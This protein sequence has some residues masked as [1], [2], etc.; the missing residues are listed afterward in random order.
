MAILCRTSRLLVVVIFFTLLASGVL[1]NGQALALP[2][3]GRSIPI[4][5]KVVLIGFSEKQIDIAHL[6]WSG[7]GKNLPESIANFDFD[8][9]NDTGVVFRPKYSFS[10]ASSDF[11]D[12]LVTYLRSIEKKGHGKNP[13]F[14]QWQ[15]D[16]KNKDYSVFEP[17]SVNYVV[18]DA[19]SV[20]DWLWNHGQ[21]LG[22]YPENA[23][24]I[25]VAYLPELPSVSWPDVRTFKNSNG[26]TLPKSTPHYYGIAHTD[27][28]LGYKS[29]YRDFMNAW[30]GHHRMWFVDLSAGPVF[31]SEWEDI[32]LQVAVGDN[33]IDLSS[34]FS[35]NWLT[36]YVADYVWQATVNFVV[37]NF[38][39]YPIY[40]PNYQ[41][42]VFILDDRS[43]AEK[44]EVPIQNTLN[45]DMV[46]AAIQDLVPYSKVSV[47]VSFVDVTQQLHDL[48]KSNYEYTDSWIYG[49]V[50]GEPQRYGIVNVKPIY[51]YM[52][53]NL[54]TFEP[55]PNKT[56]DKITIPV[57]AF[58]FTGETYF[59]YPYK[60]YIGKTD[61]ETGALLGIALKEGVFISYNQWEFTRGDQIDPSQPG[62]GEG[63]TQT[64][65]HEVGHEFGLMHPHQ[66]GDIGDFVFSAMGYFT[67]DYTFGQ[68]D[69]DAI[70]RAHVD[71]IYMETE[72]LLNQASTNPSAAQL[73][74]QAENKLSEADSAYNSMK[75][76]DA[77]QPVLAA[78]QL[79][80]Q[81]AQIQYTQQ[82]EAVTQTGTTASLIATEEPVVILAIGAVIGMVLG[83]VTAVILMRRRRETAETPNA[84]DPRTTVDTQ[85]STS[86]WCISCHRQ[87]LHESVFCENCGAR[88]PDS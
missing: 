10:F 32:P 42:D 37:P 68:T 45:K 78:Y 34:E 7:S 76:A 51:E 84:K 5:I 58:A 40:S 75:Y 69:K 64:I 54:P 27:T 73:T 87:I 65:I 79:A 29:R 50:F 82:T 26:E 30:G 43:A 41:I 47:N 85:P 1:S 66:Y 4:P 70:Q 55:N 2:D 18:Y 44:K 80:L 63:F 53:D 56:Q 38:V 81:A 86:R 15:Q 74:A 21:D 17:L 83:L 60:W 22:G 20:E 39:Y 88:Q 72:R 33:N 13:W 31:N 28:D 49:G 25:I 57:F 16:K 67:D 24:T 8:S 6:S 52:I 36:E 3:V 59:T 46:G 35:R 14:G 48:I 11:K 19:N 62:K 23:W 12:G 77:I 71:Q 9:G 61:W